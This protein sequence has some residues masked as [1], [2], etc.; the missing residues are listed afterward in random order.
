[1]IAIIKNLI[2]DKELVNKIKSSE[3][4]SNK[5]YPQ[6]IAGKITLQEYL[7]ATR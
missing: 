3:L 2:F 5:L 6:L 4:D 1:M 7:S